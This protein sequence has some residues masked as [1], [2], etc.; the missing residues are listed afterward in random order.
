M[1]K[2]KR[3]PPL[4]YLDKNT[5]LKISIPQVWKVVLLVLL[6][7]SLMFGE[8]YAQR[9]RKKSKAKKSASAGKRGK[10]ANAPKDFI[11]MR[12]PKISKKKKGKE[13]ASIQRYNAKFKD[14]IELAK[15]GPDPNSFRK[16]TEDFNP[17]RTLSLVSEDSI[18]LNDGEVS[19]V[20]VAEEIQI[21]SSWVKI[22][23]YYSLWDTRRVNPYGK[24]KSAFNEPVLLHLYDT[25]ENRLWKMPQRKTQLNSK[26]GYRWYRWHYGV[27]LELD[28]FDSLYAA[29]DGIVRVSGYDPRGYGNYIVVRH[30][31]GI[32]TVYGHLAINIAQ[33]GQY[34]KAGDLLGW[35]GSTGRS[36]GPHLHYELRYMGMPF[37]PEEIYDFSEWKLKMQDYVLTPEAFNYSS[38]GR[39]TRKVFYHRVRPG[40]TVYSIANKY[41]ISVQQLM[42]MNGLKK[43]TALRYGKRIKIR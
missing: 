12:A 30:Y 7:I 35:A 40:D 24:D 29:F 25:L 39:A 27:D 16:P 13:G 1:A 23:E 21:D 17:Y 4:M 38:G 32:E 6:A 18:G 41:G 28:M 22:A 19:V 31:N 8:G 33:P 34:V 42:R 11:Q 37:N 14:K 26:F 20:E 2:L 43:S 9:S 15:K 3:V 36:T 10:K 5:I